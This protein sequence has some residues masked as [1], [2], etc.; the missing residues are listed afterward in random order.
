MPPVTGPRVSTD[1][2]DYYAVLAAD[3]KDFTGNTDTDNRMLARSCR[4]QGV[5]VLAPAQ[6]SIWPAS[7]DGQVPV[8]VDDLWAEPR[9]V[10][11][12][13]GQAAVYLTR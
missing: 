5:R 3:I 6:W 10:C 8:R 4:N 2:D 1:L 13:P 9:Q 12:L 11:A 7:A